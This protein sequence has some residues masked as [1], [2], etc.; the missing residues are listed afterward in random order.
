MSEPSLPIGSLAP[1]IAEPRP[2]PSEA[3][4]PVLATAW[5]LATMAIQLLLVS[6]VVFAV[7]RIIP[8]DPLAMM[9]PPSAT[10]EDVE[11]MRAAFGLDRSIPEQYMIW[12]GAA[13][14]GDLGVSIQSRLPVTALIRAALP[15]TLELVVCGVV[16]G[17]AA[18]VGLGLLTFWGRGGALERFGETAASLAQA[19]PEFLWAIL[20]IL[21]FGLGFRALPFIGPIGPGMGAPYRTGFLLIDTLIAGR[22]DAFGSRLAHLVLPSIAI[23]MIK[24]PVIM[25]LLRSSL[26]EVYSEEYIAAARLRGIGEARLLLRHALRNAA[27]PTVTLIGVQIAQVLGGTLL[28]EAIYSLA[29]L[30][31][32]TIG[33][34]RTHDLPLLQGITL[35]Y[36]AVV[37]AANSLVDLMYLWLNPR[38]RAR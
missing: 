17:V 16:L 18:G 3:L 21:V 27:L 38:L 5:R 24:A 26:I 30:G 6:I 7:L 8:A 29:G 10:S 2:R 36:C 15:L 13:L 1:T 32:L 25:R 28:I 33:A 34:I 22:W 4:A 31:S 19:I 35:T 37:L 9:L 20:L 12:L 11:R 23:A 14:H